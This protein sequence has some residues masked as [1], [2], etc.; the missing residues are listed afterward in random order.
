MQSCAECGK[1]VKF[2]SGLF[3]NRIPIFDEYEERKAQGRPFPKGEYICVACDSE[4]E[5]ELINDRRSE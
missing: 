3:V 1:S 4:F 5:K 2:G